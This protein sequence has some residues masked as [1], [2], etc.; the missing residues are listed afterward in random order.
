L[1]AISA[2]TLTASELEA[3][4]RTSDPPVIVRVEDGQVLIDL[5]TVFN[6]QDEALL[7]CLQKLSS[8]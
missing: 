6:E 3:R 7:A 5:R 2:Q 1:L 4:L 8:N